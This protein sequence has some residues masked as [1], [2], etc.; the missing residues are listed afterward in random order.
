MRRMAALL[1]RFWRHECLKV[2]DRRRSWRNPQPASEAQSRKQLIPAWT[3]CPPAPGQL[4]P[5][6]RR[7]RLQSGGNALVGV[8]R[9]IIDRSISKVPWTL[10][11]AIEWPRTDQ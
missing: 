6:P 2:A 1:L 8:N 3:V 11:T 9:P 4:A 5:P 7:I 10:K